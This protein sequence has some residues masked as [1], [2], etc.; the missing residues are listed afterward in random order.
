MKM[1][2]LFQTV[3]LSFGFLFGTC[4]CL[5]AAHAEIPASSQ[6]EANALFNVVKKVQVNGIDI[7]G[8]VPLRQ[9]TH[10]LR[11]P[12][13]LS[14]TVYQQATADIYLTFKNAQTQ[15]L[16]ITSLEGLPE[17]L[18]TTIT[19][20]F[21]ANDNSP[22]WDALAQRDNGQWLLQSDIMGVWDIDWKTAD[23][24]PQSL[25][26]DGVTITPEFTLSEFAQ[27][28]PRSFNFQNGFNTPNMPG[29]N[30]KTFYLTFRPMLQD[31][32]AYFDHLEFVF[33]GEALVKVNLG[34]G[35]RY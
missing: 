11:P 15:A 27:R 16:F 3:L 23:G 19:R 33:D 5:Q 20:E 17:S 35:M 22:A 29:T 30:E 13:A 2:S 21:E 1:K 28:Y 6:D 25:K 18:Q 4:A 26:L 32:L 14:N 8:E 12:Y 24:F 34:R 9:I 7:S 31:E 10:V